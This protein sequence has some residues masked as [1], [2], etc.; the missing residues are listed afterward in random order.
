MKCR[1]L[2]ERQAVATL[3]VKNYGKRCSISKMALINCPECGREVSER[4]PSCP[5]CGAPIAQQQQW[6]P[7]YVA[8]Q[9][10]AAKKNVSCLT[11]G[12]VI[13]FVLFLIGL[14][15]GECGKSGSTSTSGPSSNGTALPPPPALSPSEA[16]L[17][18]VELVTFSW[19]KG[20]FD[21]IM[22]GTFVIKNNNA[23]AVKDITIKCTHS[24][25][26]GTEI[27]SNS[28]TIYETINA[29]KKR[30]I[31]DFNM[32]FINTQAASTR[33]QITGVVPAS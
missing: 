15:A 5:T 32:G 9:P 18:N 33:C 12:C 25:K 26:S 1:T 28:R 14:I 22:M 6:Q 24:G 30:T 23:F 27:D 19:Y 4:A 21:S 16:A 10:V 11:G 31:R 8:P 17:Q 20:G 13:L 2:T 3:A 29:K 7:S